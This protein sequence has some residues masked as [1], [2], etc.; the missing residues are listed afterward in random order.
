MPNRGAFQIRFKWLLT[1]LVFFVLPL[2]LIAFGLGKTWTTK[3]ELSL[4]K[5]YE[6]LDSVL[7]GLRTRDQTPEYLELL[8]ARLTSIATSLAAQGKD[9][10]NLLRKGFKSLRQRFP[11]VFRFYVVDRDGNLIPEL[12]EPNTAGYVLKKLY[13]LQL[14]ILAG[15]KFESDLVPLMEVLKSFVGRQAVP[16]HLAKAQCLTVVALTD[17][18]R[19]FFFLINKNLGL[20]AHLDQ[21][22]DWNNLA[23]RDSCRAF[24]ASG[25]PFGIETGL[26]DFRD[27]L[28]DSPDLRKAILEYKASNRSHIAA[29]IRLFSFLSFSNNSVVWA[30]RLGDQGYSTANY[31]VAFLLVGVSL[32]AFLIISSHKVMVEGLEFVFPIRLRLVLL[33]GF[34][35]GL[36]IVAIILA[37]WDYANQTFKNRVRESYDESERILKSFDAKFPQMQGQ[38]EASF[39]SIFSKCRYSSPDEMKRTEKVFQFLWKKVPTANIRMF[40]GQGKAV[41]GKS[42]ESNLDKI[43]GNLVTKILGKVNNEEGPELLYDATGLLLEAVGG[44]DQLTLLTNRLGLLQTLVF[45]GNESW[46]YIFPLKDVS[47]RGTHL[48]FINWVKANLERLYIEYALPREKK[49]LND[50]ILYVANPIRGYHFPS[51]FS[52]IKGLERFTKNIQLRQGVTWGSIRMNGRNYLLTG[53]KPREL[54]SHYLVAIQC[55]DGIKA[56]IEHL[57]NLLLLFSSISAAISLFLG[58]LLSERFLTPIGRL[59]VGVEAIRKRDFN[60]RLPPGQKDELGELA[61]TFNK[62]I[63]GLSDLEVAK[64]VQESLFPPESLSLETY[65][66]YGKSRAMTDIGGDYLD[67]FK[68]GDDKIVG[69]IGDVS[70]HGIGAALIMGMAKCAFTM[71]ED[72][73]DNLVGN[74]NNFSKFLLRTIKRKKMM[75]L[76]HFCVNVKTH[77]IQ[78]ANGGHNF[79][80][81]FDF[82]KRISEEMKQETFPLGMRLKVNYFSMEKKMEPGDSI[83]FYTDGFVEASNI[84]GEVLDYE[85]GKKWFEE[86]SH[87]SAIETVEQLKSRFDDYTKGTEPGDDMSLICLKRL[88]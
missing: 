42:E 50:R 6:N 61:L 45:G 40:D 44:E 81:Y 54:S 20:Y 76:F 25:N 53:I 52:N 51:R 15:R 65:Q 82:E 64:T 88:S 80:F 69:L 49:D 55:D 4:T 7:L 19:N 38:L 13:L 73:L 37:S 22:P 75:T 9:Y 27:S 71:H 83:L 46:V 14:D 36:P 39:N 18:G 8:L 74:L 34:A 84:K 70:G 43:M 28:P 26:Y 2:L 35:G 60:H 59:S 16:Y 21:V 41:L 85:R 78:F 67:Y 5:A 31:R 33:F 3:E 48:V 57:Q 32:V 66:I 1:C 47:G 10:L 58:V 30:S 87:L 29:G 77:V 79:P 62:V 24:N 63:E 12:T 11:G 86:L 17:R 68:V 23:I 56:E 72:N